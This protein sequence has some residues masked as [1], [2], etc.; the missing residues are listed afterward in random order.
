M[1][2]VVWDLINQPN[3]LTFMRERD[4][5]NATFVAQFNLKYSS[6]TAADA[7]RLLL[8]PATTVHLIS[9]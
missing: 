3:M 2:A 8:M 6:Q 9:F 5:K 7:K 1:N 4:N